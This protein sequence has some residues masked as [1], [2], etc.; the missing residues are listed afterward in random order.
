MICQLFNNIK[1]LQ[2]SSAYLILTFVAPPISNPNSIDE[3]TFD[4][5]NEPSCRS[6]T[7]YRV[8]PNPSSARMAT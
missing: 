4:S 7:I 6:V 2:I 5:P 1:S 8:H 3:T